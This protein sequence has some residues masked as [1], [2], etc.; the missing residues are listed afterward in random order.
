MREGNPI[1]ADTLRGAGTYV[2]REKTHKTR[3]SNSN[4]PFGHSDECTKCLP[5]PSRWDELEAELAQLFG[6]ASD[7]A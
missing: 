7:E 6:G 3:C 5:K 1:Q 4:N 2:V